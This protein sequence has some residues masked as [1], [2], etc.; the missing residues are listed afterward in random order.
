MQSQSL[1]LLLLLTLLHGRQ[2]LRRLLLT[3]YC[4]RSDWTSA[5]TEHHL[6]ALTWWLGCEPTR[7]IALPTDWT[8]L[9]H[10]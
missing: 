9:W 6:R 8:W 3:S 10:S 7:A 5:W 2:V 4:R 1:Y